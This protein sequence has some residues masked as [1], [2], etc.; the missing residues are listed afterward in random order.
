MRFTSSLSQPLSLSGS[1]SSSVFSSCFFCFFC[2]C[3]PLPGWGDADRAR[4]TRKPRRWPPPAARNPP[5]DGGGGSSSS[6]EYCGGPYRGAR[7]LARWGGCLLLSG[8][9]PKDLR[10]GG[11]SS[12]LVP[13]RAAREDPP[14]EGA[15]AGFF[16]AFAAMSLTDGKLRTSL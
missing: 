4:G 14:G 1:S 15:G 8:T 10:F 3:W 7:G 6:S 16:G 11:S 2:C 9:S 12:F 13:I 5:R